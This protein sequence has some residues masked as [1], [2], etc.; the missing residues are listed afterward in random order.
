MHLPFVL[1]PAPETHMA[2]YSLLGE[3]YF[4]EIWYITFTVKTRVCVAGGAVL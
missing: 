2:C 4:V 3:K 1:V